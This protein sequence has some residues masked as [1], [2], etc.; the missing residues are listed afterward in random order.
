MH[1]RWTLTGVVALALVAI[2]PS[3]VVQATGPTVTIEDLGPSGF[4]TGGRGVNGSSFT[5]G[6]GNDGVADFGFTQQTAPLDRAAA[7]WRGDLACARGQRRWRGDGPLHASTV[8]SIL[9]ATTR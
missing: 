2:G 6:C 1:A 7:G 4:T 5:V 3:H 9:T 8:S